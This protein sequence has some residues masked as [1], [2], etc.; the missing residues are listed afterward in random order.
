MAAK[1][2]EVLSTKEVEQIFHDEKT[3]QLAMD[4][5]PLFIP[6][7]PLN[8]DKFRFVSVNGVQYYLAVGKQIEV[9]VCVAEVYHDSYAR[10]QQ[11][12]AQI[13]TDVEIN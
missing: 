2:E 3:K 8:I 11:A 9:P 13:T 7:D 6:E 1:K 12:K 5:V 4:K 10:T